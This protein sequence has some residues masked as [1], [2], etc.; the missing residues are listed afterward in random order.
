MG[1]LDD[2]E[3][4]LKKY[5][6]YYGEST[7]VFYQN[8]KFFE[9]YGVDNEVEKFGN[10]KELA[11][12][13][14]I[15]STRKNTG[16]LENNRSNYL[17]AGFPCIQLDK[18]VTKMTEQY[19]YVVIVVE[20]IG[21]GSDD[22]IK[23]DVT[24][25][26]TPGS[27]IRYLSK[28]DANNI[29]CLYIENLKQFRG[30]NLFTIS[31]SSIDVSTGLSKVSQTWNSYEDENTATDATMR[32]MELA[33]PKEMLIYY[34]GINQ[35]QA[36]KILNLDISSSVLKHVNE[37][38]PR[39]EMGEIS[40]QNQFLK[41]VYPDA[42][43]ITP[44]EYIGLSKYPSI[45]TSFCLLLDFCYNQ[46]EMIISNIKVPELLENM[47]RLI[48]DNCSAEQLNILSVEQG[49]MKGKKERLTNVISLV[50]FT[51]TPMGKRYLR[52]RLLSPYVREEDIIPIYDKIEKYRND[53][54]YLT[55]EKYL[56]GI[57]DIE[58]CHRK[59]FLK[60]LN[61]SDFNL[62]KTSY[63]NIL[64]IL[65]LENENN[66]SEDIKNHLTYLENHLDF[67]QTI[68]FNIQDI[69]QSIFKYGLYPDLDFYEDQIREC[70]EFC[71]AFA[72]EIS[73]I[74]SKKK[75]E[76]I[77]LEHQYMEDIGYF[78]EITENR[79]STL[80]TAGKMS[81]TLNET[82][83]DINLLELKPI[84][85]TKT[86]KVHKVTHPYLE[87]YNIVK[88]SRNNFI[89]GIKKR[90]QI[91]LSDTYIKYSKCYG[92]MVEFIE[93]VDYYKSGAKCSLLYNYSRPIIEKIDLSESYVTA[94]DLRHPLIE[95]F[96]NSFS[97][98]PQSI[99]FLKDRGILLFGINCSGKSSLMKAIGI[100]VILAQ[101]GYY[102]PAK[103]YKYYP[104]KSIMTR[105]VGNDNLF[106]G[107]SSFAVEMCE[108]RSIIKRSD[109]NTL[110][111][112]D[113]I[114]KGTETLSAVSI[115]ASTIIKLSE[116]KVT[117]LFATHL[118]HLSELEEVVNKVSM[119]H[120]SITYDA[121]LDTLIYN[122]KLSKGSGSS[123][124]GLEV[125]KAMNFPVEFIEMANK[126]RKEISDVKPLFP[127]K[128]SIY[129]SE[130]YLEKCSIPE[131]KRNSTDTHHIKFQCTADDKGYIDHMHKN[132]RSNL[133]PLCKPCH[134]MV[135]CD[136]KGQY[137]Y[138][139]HG[140]DYSLKGL[141]LK[142]EKVL[143]E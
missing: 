107:L 28:Y 119:Y 78:I 105:I 46:N 93:R 61:P 66:L 126:I 77:D 111:L 71:E 64:S 83:Y 56:E 10:V 34:E 36:D 142:Y 140:F 131:C 102:V 134:Q 4:V 59:I 74:L 53:N 73:N 82:T 9:I 52:E 16:V 42:T 94:K 139:I 96:Q 57:N 40:Y 112:G 79:L 143:N 104:Y 45:V 44:I 90:Y 2:Y 114:C 137:R 60:M 72:K 135:H 106:K 123:L 84:S 116:A 12:M 39:K 118:H 85:S 13:L 100:S 48:L 22:L 128:K 108:L 32:F 6:G 99:D 23:R 70:E 98:V 129:N 1:I 33:N 11:E 43:L 92:R 49:N 113:E 69:S 120:L 109:K 3:R 97:Y 76:R 54:L 26:I 115:V 138:I 7:V 41:K 133:I 81:F 47:E 17:L 136:K 37:K 68:K 29:V 127:E 132:H 141:I 122:R 27:N 103:E 19:N 25:I 58:R 95:R 31:M 67:T 63:E 88:E 89:Q 125:A 80:K 8:G 30:K 18:Y 117:F 20:Q 50:N 35:E 101:A 91:F 5:Q 121:K 24:N 87:K 62:L 51:S 75:K 38:L 15:T 65:S 110:V 124:Y 130:V 14:C 55:Y 86:G 21:I